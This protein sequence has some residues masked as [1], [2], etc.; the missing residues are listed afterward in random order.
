MTVA[1]VDYGM[2]NLRSVEKALERVGADAVISASAD[3]IAAAEGIVLPGVGAFPRA[4]EE[5]DRRGLAGVVRDAA[6]SGKPVLGICL[7]MQLLFER[8]SEL[9]GAPGL[10][11]IPGEV[12]PL[13]AGRLKLPQIGWN[14]V[15]WS[16]SSELTAGLPDPC[17]FYH[18]HSFAGRPSDPA[19]ALGT[20]TYGAPFVTA[21]QR[22]ALFGVQFHP[23]KSGEHGLALLANF[24]GICAARP[25]P[26]E[27]AR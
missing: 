2:G 26:T 22:G 27:A 4:V 10:G 11:L 20:S 1:I 6:T 14:P 9:G 18:V 17:A 8:S 25:T 23:E 21:V 15:G 16:R 24:T 13:S 19:D 12:K 5:I 3:Q 7:G